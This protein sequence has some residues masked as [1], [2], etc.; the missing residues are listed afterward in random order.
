ML[1][2]FLRNQALT[3]NAFQ[4]TGG[5]TIIYYTGK[6]RPGSYVLSEAWRTHVPSAVATLCAGRSA[7]A[8][9]DHFA[10]AA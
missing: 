2:F 9:D 5:Y 10:Q 6:V 8:E 4:M 3:E 1:T 7:G